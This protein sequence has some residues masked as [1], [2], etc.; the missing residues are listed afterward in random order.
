MHRL[1]TPAY[2][3]KRIADD[4]KLLLSVF[5]GIT[6]AASLIAGAPVYIRTLER[7][8]LNTAID[9]SS[10][11]FLNLFVF[12]PH[13]PLNKGSLDRTDRSLDQAVRANSSQIYRGR[14]RLLRAPVY[15]VGLPWRPLPTADGN[16]VSRGYFQHLSN[17]QRHVTFVEGRM[18]TDAVSAGP[19]GPVIE[20][21]VGTTSARVFDLKIEDSVTLTP[22]IGDPT[23]IS[24]KIV[25]IIDPIDRSEEYWHGNSGVLLE[26]QPLTGEPDL[27]IEVDPEEPPVP[28][29]ITQHAMAEGLGRAYPGTLV[30][31]SWVVL[32]DKERLKGWSI[33]ETRDSLKAIEDDVLLSMARIGRA[34][35]NKEADA[36]F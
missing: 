27:E 22:S 26:P 28:L 20:A 4:W 13:I 32:V 3:I 21:V 7:L 19:R 33:A 18:A 8:S 24:A 1:S 15:L 36:R 34:H 10:N 2:I 25:G 23:R 14:E 17:L 12:A 30:S 11:V 9:R 16:R 31:S 29:F 6:I 35:G 5:L